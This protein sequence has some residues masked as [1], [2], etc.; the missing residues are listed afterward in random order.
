MVSYAILGATGRIGGHVLD[1]REKDSTIELHL[2]ARSKSKILKSHP[3]FE[4]NKM[5]SIYEGDLNDI[6]VIKDC[7]DGTQTQCF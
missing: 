6:Q 2:Y 3:E 5:V 4:N 7:I 1:L